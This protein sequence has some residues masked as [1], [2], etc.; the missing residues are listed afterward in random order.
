MKV[1]KTILFIPPYISTRWSSVSTLSQ[2][3]TD[4]IQV[5]LTDKNAISIPYL[6]QEQIEQIFSCHLESLE[7]PTSAHHPEYMKQQDF[8]DLIALVQ[9]GIKEIMALI[10]KL[11][12][13]AIS[14]VGKA[15]E[16]DSKN[17]KM[18]LL[19]PEMR[20][21]VLMLLNVI[22]KE[23]ILGMPL[24]E[25]DCNCMYCQISRILRTELEFKAENSDEEKIAQEDALE[26]EVHEHDLEFSEWS[27][28]PISEKLF[29][30]RNK[31]EPYEEYRVFLGNPIGC[32][33][34][35]PN[36]EH[37]VAALRS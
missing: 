2:I 7:E 37:I 29:L 25:P 13:T 31:L 19:S 4:T 15:L 20:E 21:K 17:S 8:V 36:C 33:C 34:G 9:S 1:T 30:V 14:S 28:S 27:V 32:T 16:H 11:G 24:P 5:I 23:D 26:E 22:P 35:K 10:L 3:N 12:S 6:S 18:A